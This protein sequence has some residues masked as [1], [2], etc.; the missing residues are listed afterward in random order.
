[1]IPSVVLHRVSVVAKLGELLPEHVA[2]RKNFLHLS[3]LPIADL[4]KIS[5]GKIIE[6]NYKLSVQVQR[7]QRNINN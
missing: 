7:K 1:M 5:P 4:E 2:A 6:T 3:S